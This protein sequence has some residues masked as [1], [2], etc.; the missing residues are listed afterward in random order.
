MPDPYTTIT[1]SVRLNLTFP[2]KR[3]NDPVLA[4]VVKKFNVTVDIRRAQ[5]EENVGGYIMLEMTGTDES[6][7]ES[8]NYMKALGVGVGFIGQEDVGSY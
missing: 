4:D 3:V 5:V 1:N 2:T 7:D 6:I 8:V